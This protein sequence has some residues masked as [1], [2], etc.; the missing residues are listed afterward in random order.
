MPIDVD[1]DTGKL[2]TVVKTNC[3][4]EYALLGAVLLITLIPYI[5]LFWLHPLAGLGIVLGI[6]I[7]QMVVAFS[8]SARGG[9]SHH[10]RFLLAGSN[11]IG[12]SGGA[13]LLLGGVDSIFDWQED[14]AHRR[15]SPLKFWWTTA[16][17][18]LTTPLGVVLMVLEYLW[19][20]VLLRRGPRLVKVQVARIFFVGPLPQ[21]HLS[22]KVERHFLRRRGLRQISR[23]CFSL[24]MESH[25]GDGLRI[26][27]VQTGH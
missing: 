14:A 2:H 18:F 27:A 8:S 22:G 17:K 16:L 12:M 21:F 5:A 1:F 3:R 10:V 15:N 6:A 9:L 25:A 7:F 23:Q 11:P 13:S 24:S 4:A 19:D 20:L 26:A